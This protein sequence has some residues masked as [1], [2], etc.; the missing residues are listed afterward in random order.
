MMM[1]AGVVILSYSCAST[2][3]PTNA[4]MMPGNWVVDEFYVNGQTNGSSIFSRFILERDG[5][6][7]LEDDNGILFAGTWSA[8]A[9]NL[10]LNASDGTVFDFAIVYMAFSKMQLVQT[11][12]GGSAGSLE[13]RYLLNRSGNN[14]TY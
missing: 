6:F 8:S 9:S 13:I 2:T 5:S 4:E 3:A 14:T 10:T 7:V 1:L 11:L 12:S